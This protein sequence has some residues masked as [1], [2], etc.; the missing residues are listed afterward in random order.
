MHTKVIGNKVYA[1]ETDEL[2]AEI[3][4]KNYKM[5]KLF[6]YTNS[7][8]NIPRTVEF[9]KADE[10]NKKI[11]EKPVRAMYTY[12]GLYICQYCNKPVMRIFEENVRSGAVYVVC[13][14]G[15][16]YDFKYFKPAKKIQTPR[17]G[18]IHKL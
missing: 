12:N 16:V 17:K 4:L 7:N 5:I 10:L 3:Y 18:R 8:L 6:F 15:A 11:S 13:Q 2:I 14:C 1:D 9:R